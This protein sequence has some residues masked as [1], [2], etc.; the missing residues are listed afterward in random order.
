MPITLSPNHR[1]AIVGKTGSGKSWFTMM[2]ASLLV[3]GDDPHWQVWWLDSKLDPKDAKQLREWGFGRRDCPARKHI[4]LDPRNGPINWQAQV[5]CER[6]LARRNV[7]LVIDEYKHVV[8]S[9]RRAGHG[10]QR[11]HIQGRGLN[12]GNIG[13]TQEPVDIPRQLISQATHIFLFDLTYPA[14]IR[15]ARSLHPGYERPPDRHG[16]YHAHIDGEA[17]WRYY[18]HMRAWYESIVP[19]EQPA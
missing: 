14:D 18:P 19:S 16:F 15:Y 13:E 12:V 11:T 9:T 10:I 7:L 6:A 17:V 8:L 3:P 1:F 2:L 4:R 5:L